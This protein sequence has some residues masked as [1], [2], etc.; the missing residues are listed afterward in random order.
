VGEP[1]PGRGDALRLEHRVH[2]AYRRPHDGLDF[3]AGHDQGM[4][5]VASSALPSNMSCV[6]TLRGIS[7]PLFW[8]EK[9][10]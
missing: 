10:E 7:T 6:T 9:E 2:L 4:H 5:A 8:N 1:R 3:I